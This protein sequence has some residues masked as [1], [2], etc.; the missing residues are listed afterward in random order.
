MTSNGNEKNSTN[1]RRDFLKTGGVVAAGMYLGGKQTARAADKA[2][3]ALAIDGGPKAVTKSFGERRQVAPI[4]RRRDRGGHHAAEEPQLRARSPSSRKRGSSDSAAKYVKA[5]CN[6]TS[7]LG[8]AFFALD[9]PPGSEVLVSSYSTWFP[10]SPARFYGIVP[11]FVDIDPKTFNID[12]EDCK[13]RL[14]KDT[15]A[16]LPVHWWGLPCEMDR[17]C[18]FAKEHGLEVIEDG[19]HAH[20]S[21]LGDTNIGNWGRV[22]GFSLQM[23]KPLP[24]IEG[25]IGVY[26]DQEAYERATT[27]GNYDLPSS[28]PE[29]SPYRKY[30]GTAFGWK[31]RMHPASAILAEIQLQRL[32]ENNRVVISQVRTLNDRITQLP[33]LS[34]PT[35]RPDMKRVYYSTNLMF[36][37]EAKAGMSRDAC[38]KALAAEGVSVSSYGWSLL[39]NY[40]FFQE[41][42][43]WHHAPADPGELPGCDQANHT[44]I[45]LPLM[46]AEDPELVEQYAKAFEKVW[47]HREK[48]GK[49]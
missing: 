36:L 6:G 16:I 43:W 19:S 33:G 41:E 13:R 18:D 17:I 25:G 28:F 40:P 4:R 1:S 12:V 15:K 21:S 30:Q 8:S 10:L 3:E 7:S 2:P 22:A 47:A 32:D 42:K 27:F 11:R 44:A 35:C 34:E 38:V 26:K 14:T 20:G 37:D 39:H 23:S 45:S 9:L 46:H 49:G 29:G 24:S 31:F 48:V 5:H